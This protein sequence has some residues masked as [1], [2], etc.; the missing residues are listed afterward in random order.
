MPR[1]RARKKVWKL[2]KDKYR[3]FVNFC[4]FLWFQKKKK[5]PTFILLDPAVEAVAGAD[6]LAEVA[7]A[8]N[9]A[10]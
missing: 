10:A 6:G 2:P 8:V 5:S 1:W 9:I 7:V 3:V 4:V